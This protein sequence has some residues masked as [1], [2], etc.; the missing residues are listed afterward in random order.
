MHDEVVAD[1]RTRLEAASGYALGDEEVTFFG[2][3]PACRA[4]HGYAAPHSPA[5][6]QVFAP[7]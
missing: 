3:C 5:G 7:V 4:V 2:L 6:D 1:A